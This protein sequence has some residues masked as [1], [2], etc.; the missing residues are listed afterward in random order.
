MDSRDK[1]WTL[2]T[3][4]RASTALIYKLKNDAYTFEKNLSETK[5]TINSL[6]VDQSSYKE[7]I[8]ELKKNQN[9]N[10]DEINLGRNDYSQFENLHTAN[11]ILKINKLQLN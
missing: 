9:Y 11:L 10:M 6:F 1:N 8:N 7:Q 3:V 5:E 2:R 4:E